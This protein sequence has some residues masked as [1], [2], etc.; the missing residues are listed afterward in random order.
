MFVF[1]N[2]NGETLIEHRLSP[3]GLE[4]DAFYPNGSV[5]ET[6]KVAETDYC[7]NALLREIDEEFAGAIKVIDFSYLGIV[8]AEAIGVVFY[9]YFIDDWDGT[10]PAFTVEDGL[11]FGELK[12]YGAEAIQSVSRFDTAKIINAMVARHLEIKQ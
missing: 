8:K 2:Q 7:V 11:P 5:E 6:D 3:D 10:F 1:A 9:V 4:D 12:W